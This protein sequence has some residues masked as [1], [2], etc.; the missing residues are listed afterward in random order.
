MQSSA[1]SAESSLGASKAPG[2]DLDLGDGALVLIAAAVGAALA[3]GAAIYVVYIAPVLFAE[4][5]L[6]AALA[7]G[8]YRRV[9][10]IHGDHWVRSAV[11]RTIGP[12]IVAAVLLAVSG[13]LMQSV[14]PGASSIGRVWERAMQAEE[15]EQS[16]R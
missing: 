6:D 3:L 13:A 10:G 14:Y 2:F 9:R 7:A 11:R 16:R 12:A 8:L 5:L 15:G 4:L 1:S